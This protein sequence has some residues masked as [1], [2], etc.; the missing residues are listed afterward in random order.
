MSPAGPGAAGTGEGLDGKVVLVSGAARGQGEA[1][2]RLLVARGARVVLGDVLDEQG[3]AVA[4]DL[5]DDA[6]YLRLDVA[7]P[8]HWAGAVDHAVAAF[9]RLDAVVNNAGI[10]RTGL[11]EDTALDDYLAVVQV[12]QVGCFLGMRA[13]I[14]PLRDTG[15]GSIVN[16]SSTAGIE[17][18]PGV[19]AYVASKFAIRGMTKTAALELGRYGIRVNSVHPGTI[20][21][22]M[23]DAPEFAGVDK[24]AVFAALP[25]PRI[26]RP[27]DVAEMV[28]FLV[29]DRA[30]YCSGA[31]FVVDGGALAGSPMN[32]S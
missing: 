31:E 20:D 27:A 6:R 1:E 21:T 7:D 11:I 12:N 10:V 32:I 4:A 5:G 22:P 18:V 19:V 15:G 9:G 28:A 25:V 3:E 24:E 2:A 17:G 26:G 16:V 23:V 8:N 13:A 30:S 14:A 29:S